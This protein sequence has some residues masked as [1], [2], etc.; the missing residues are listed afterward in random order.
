MNKEKKT[1]PEPLYGALG[2]ILKVKSEVNK[3]NLVKVK[4]LKTDG[5]EIPAYAHDGDVGMD[6]V[7]TAV[8]YLADIDTFV[9]HTGIYCETD[10][11]IGC[12]LLARSSNRKTDAYLPN[13]LGLID[14][15]TYRGE[16]CFSFKNRTDTDLFAAMDAMVKYDEL[17]FW[18]KPF[19][20]F[21]K[22][23]NESAEEI[24]KNPLQLAPYQV[25]DRIGQMVF[26]RHPTVEI[27]L[28]D[29]LSDTERGEGG[30]GST[31]N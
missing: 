31:G 27:E 25:G 29:K 4:M 22:V 23:W 1:K 26:F 2:E 17:P 16:W 10:K 21:R 19:T 20:S 12:F 3:T 14:T 30:H 13:G 18:K 9:Y 11:N 5:L 24:K 15:F 6:V 7:A 28:V 8:E